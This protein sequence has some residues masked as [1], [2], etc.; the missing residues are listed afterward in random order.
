M[1]NSCVMFAGVKPSDFESK[2]LHCDEL[3]GMISR[4]LEFTIYVLAIDVRE[5][6][7]ETKVFLGNYGAS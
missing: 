1:V 6:R 4:E 2:M 3:E 5:G 7:V